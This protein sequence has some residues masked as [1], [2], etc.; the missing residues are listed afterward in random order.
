MWAN[1]ERN[2]SALVWLCI[3]SKTN[4]WF[5]CCSSYLTGEP[6]FW[7]YRSISRSEIGSGRL[8]SSSLEGITL[9]YTYHDQQVFN[10]YISRA[11]PRN[12]DHSKHLLIMTYNTVTPSTS[13]RKV[14][15]PTELCRSWEWSDPPECFV[16]PEP[17][18]LQSWAVLKLYILY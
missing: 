14:P 7:A 8:S 17:W 9:L 13:S 6:M 10:C 3:S 2:L 11:K 12:T 16:W 1:T 4:R 5:N 18:A 15:Q